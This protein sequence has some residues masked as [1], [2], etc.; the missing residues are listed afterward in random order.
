MHNVSSYK[1]NSK[2]LTVIYRRNN[3]VF[4]IC[5]QYCSMKSVWG[6]KR[7][8]TDKILVIAVGTE[9]FTVL[10]PLL[11]NMKNYLIWKFKPPSP[12]ERREGSLHLVGTP[13]EDRPRCWGRGRTGVSPSHMP[14]SWWK[15]RTHLQKVESELSTTCSRGHSRHRGGGLGKASHA[16]AE[17]LPAKVTPLVFK[18]LPTSNFTKQTYFISSHI[19]K[20]ILYIQKT[21]III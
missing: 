18:V 10:S 12:R 20:Q 13:F 2:S 11:G 21:D 15:E 6:V 1:T 5:F 7:Y 9:E 16:L 4:G 8:K 17:L 3:T 19:I 14:L